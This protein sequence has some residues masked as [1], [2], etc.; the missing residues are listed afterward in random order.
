L[1]KYF[2]FGKL[3]GGGSKDDEKVTRGEDF[4]V[5]GGSG[6]EHKDVVEIIRVFGEG[7]KMDGPHHAEQIL[8]DAVKKVK[9]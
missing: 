6:Q 1:G 8:K 2:F 3:L 9:G 7:V 4:V 5:E